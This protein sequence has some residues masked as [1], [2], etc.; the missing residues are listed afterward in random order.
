MCLREKSGVLSVINTLANNRA[1]KLNEIR[2]TITFFLAL[3]LGF[4]LQI[5]KAEI[6]Y[7]CSNI[8]MPMVNENI[9]QYLAFLAFK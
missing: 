8:I 4:I 9:M 7:K 2:R 5:V 1:E 6:Q 3:Y